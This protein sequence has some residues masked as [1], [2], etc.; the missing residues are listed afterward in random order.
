MLLGAAVWSVPA[1]E[2]SFLLVLFS[3]WMETVL[4]QEGQDVCFEEQM[5]WEQVLGRD[6]LLD[7]MY[8]VAMV[9]IHQQVASLRSAHLSPTRG[10]HHKM[11]DSIERLNISK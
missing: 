8:W 9:W 3:P 6:I 1:K 10:G 7:L 5:H 4:P 11:S 2:L